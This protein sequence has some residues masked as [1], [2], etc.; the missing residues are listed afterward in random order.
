MVDLEVGADS[1]S[2]GWNHVSGSILIHSPRLMLTHP[3]AAWPRPI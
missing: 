1:G 3:L 2:D